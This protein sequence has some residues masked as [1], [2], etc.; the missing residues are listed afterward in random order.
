MDINNIKQQLENSKIK[1]LEEI[2]NIDDSIKSYPDEE[3]A[4][5]VEGA[6]MMNSKIGSFGIKDNLLEVLSDIDIALSKIKKNKYGICENC[7]NP[8]EEKRLEMY[9]F[10][11]YCIKCM[12]KFEDD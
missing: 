8:I 10:A 7:K 9:P 12:I 5:E 1:I 2:S 6:D 3:I 4:E 11:R